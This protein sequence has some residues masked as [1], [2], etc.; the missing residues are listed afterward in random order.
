MIMAA[1][2]MNMNLNVDDLLPTRFGLYHHM[3]AFGCSACY[4]LG[5][6]TAGL[7]NFLVPRLEADGWRLTP[8]ET[9]LL[10]DHLLS[11]RRR[12]QGDGAAI[13]FRPAALHQ[14]AAHQPVDGGGHGG[15]RDPQPAGDIADPAAGRLGHA[16][17]ALRVQRVQRVLRRRR[18]L[19]HLEAAGEAFEGAGQLRDLVW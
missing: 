15:R 6:I 16:D 1:T 5:G 18:R 10:V 3:L 12:G 8:L 2:D 7:V 14:A 17:Q 4:S 9:S 11:L 19:R 13:A